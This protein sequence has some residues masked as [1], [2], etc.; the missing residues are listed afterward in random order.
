MTIH[1]PK[2][3]SYDTVQKEWMNSAL[4]LVCVCIYIYEFCTLPWCVCVCV[5]VYTHTHTH[6]HTH[7]PR[8]SAEFI[9]SCTV[10]RD[11][12]LQVIPWRI[13]FLLF[14][15]K[16]EAA[17]SSETVIPIF[18]TAWHCISECNLFQWNPI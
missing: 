7:T 18:Q 8:K 1:F 12:C 15:L 14:C 16:M 3:V 5:C 9:R 13:F 11:P 17:V 4:F 10:G 2:G 6:T